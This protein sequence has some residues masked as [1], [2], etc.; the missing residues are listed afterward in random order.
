MRSLFSRAEPG[1]CTQYFPS[2]LRVKVRWFLTSDDPSVLA[3]AHAR[4]GRRIWSTRSRGAADGVGI[5]HARLC[6]RH[7]GDACAY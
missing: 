7:I 6:H 3:E 1:Q 4:Y 2:C 5:L